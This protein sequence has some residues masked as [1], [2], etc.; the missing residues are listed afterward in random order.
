MKECPSN[1]RSCP[2]CKSKATYRDLRPL[3]AK[4]VCVVDRTDEYRLKDQF[5]SEQM[6]VALL[7]Q[8]VAMLKIELDIQRKFNNKLELQLQEIKQSTIDL[9]LDT[10]AAS[11]SQQHQPIRSRNYKL[12]RERTINI[13]QDPGCRVLMHGRQINSLIVSQKSTQS[14]FPGFG[15]RFIDL[16]T[17]RPSQFLHMASKQIRDLSFDSDG[18]LMAAASLDTTVKLYN[19]NNRQCAGTFNPCDKSVWSVAFDSSRT[20]LLYVGTQH[21]NTYSYDIRQPATALSEHKTVGDMSP[22]INICSIPPKEPNFP[23]GGFLV[24]KLQSIW[25]YEY[26][27]S[28]TVQA[29]KLTVTGPFVSMNYCER[30]GYILIATRPTSTNPVCRYMVADLRKVDHTAMLHVT[31]TMPG[32]K[33]QAVMSRCTQISI[34][35][36]IIVAAYLQDNKALQTWKILPNLQQY[37]RLQT[38][39]IEDCVLDTCPIYMNND[40][41]VYIGALGETKCRIFKVN[42]EES[43]S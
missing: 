15:V 22:V 20:K 2:S 36:S 19:V 31:V 16:P 28:Q 12:F 41:D 14:L 11:Q 3:F 21:G 30:S 18:E 42:C 29:T 38:L 34:D 4:R 27:A 33:V 13:C 24:C 10:L 25:F 1:Q 37:N 32:S 5:E 40:N 8:D 26:T 39:P 23:F 7:N 17:F 35:D 6:K 9:T 43:S